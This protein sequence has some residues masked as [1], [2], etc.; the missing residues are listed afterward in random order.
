M[1]WKLLTNGDFSSPAL[2]N[3]STICFSSY[4]K[5]YSINSYGKINWSNK[6]YGNDKP[7][8]DIN[9]N[10]ILYI[11]GSINIINGN[12]NW[13]SGGS[14]LPTTNDDFIYGGAFRKFYRLNKQGKLL[15]EFNVSD[16]LKYQPVI[17]PDEVFIF[18]H[19][20]NICTP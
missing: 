12:F 5:I 18:L 11:G 13:S 4:Y 2:I 15:S 6:F 19:K 20:I 7:V 10:S 8:I 14:T 16:T 17:G 3:D 1:K 9:Q